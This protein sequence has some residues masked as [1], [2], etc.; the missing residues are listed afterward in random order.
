M[1]H[2]DAERAVIN[3][4]VWSPTLFKRIVWQLEPDHFRN[5]DIRLIF[6]F[7]KEHL[8]RWNDA[9]DAHTIYDRIGDASDPV[10]ETEP[11]LLFRTRFSDVVNTLREIEIGGVAPPPRPSDAGGAP[12]RDRL[13]V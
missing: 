11:E 1:T 9:P 10:F 12:T 6:E 4:L 7:S 13:G 8:R 3:Y 2:P 5:P